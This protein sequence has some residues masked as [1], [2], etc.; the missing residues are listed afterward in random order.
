MILQL[1]SKY[2]YYDSGLSSQVNPD[3][4]FCK[5][6]SVYWHFLFNICSLI[7]S[8]FFL[9]RR[10][11]AASCA[12]RLC[13]TAIR[14]PLTPPKN[15]PKLLPDNPLKALAICFALLC[16]L[17]NDWMRKFFTSG[18]SI[19]QYLIFKMWPFS[20]HRAGGAWQKVKL[21]PSIDHPGVRSTESRRNKPHRNHAGG[22][23]QRK[24]P[25][26]CHPTKSQEKIREKAKLPQV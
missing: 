12:M 6:I 1:W 13:I 26:W 10:F 20:F 25:P 15:K 8:N 18:G 24:S 17:E 21:R 4:H 14:A 19:Y 9:N 3:F 7:F 16:D 23:R 22:V 5:I 11:C 2:R